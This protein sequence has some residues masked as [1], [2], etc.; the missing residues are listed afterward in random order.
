MKKAAHQ[1]ALCLARPSLRNW[2]YSV[3]ARLKFWRQSR[4]PKTGSRDEA[5]FLAASP[6]VTAPPSNLSQIYYNGSAA[7]PH[8]TTTQYR[9]LRRLSATQ[10]RL[11]LINWSEYF[12]TQTNYFIP[13]Q[14][15]RVLAAHWIRLWQAHVFLVLYGNAAYWNYWKLTKCPSRVA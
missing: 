4:V 13:I 8:S 6:L 12:K 15:H 1:F 5:V 11:L 3:G 2:R 10:L 7:K 14:K 9:Q